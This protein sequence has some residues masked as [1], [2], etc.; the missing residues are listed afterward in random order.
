MVKVIGSQYIFITCSIHLA[1]AR[2]GLRLILGK[3]GTG[4]D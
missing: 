1:V 3:F 2:S 4:I